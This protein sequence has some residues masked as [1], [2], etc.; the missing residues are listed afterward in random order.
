MQNKQNEVGSTP[1]IDVDQLTKFGKSFVTNIKDRWEHLPVEG[2]IAYQGSIFPEKLIWDGLDYRT[3]VVLEVLR[4]INTL[5][6][7]D[8]TL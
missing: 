3:P 5:K 2:K 7:D 6:S 1:K 4:G 8:V